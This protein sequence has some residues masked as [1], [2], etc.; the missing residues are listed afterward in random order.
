MSVTYFKRFRM[1]I[2]LRGFVLPPG[3]LPPGYQL[4]RWH[5]SLLEQHAEA[6]YRSFCGEIDAVVS[7]AAAG[8]LRR[9]ADAV[10][11]SEPIR[12]S[13]EERAEWLAS[14]DGVTLGS[15]GLI[16][17]RD[18]IDRAHQSGVRYIVQPGG[19]LRNEDTIAAAD[20]YGMVMVS[21]GTRLFHH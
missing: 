16:P 17:F 12:L 11:A 14:V 3:P 21:T 10:L 7:G 1:E 15:D 8:R 13:D 5:R 6:K 18:T 9:E 2:P 19:A 4:S 20:E